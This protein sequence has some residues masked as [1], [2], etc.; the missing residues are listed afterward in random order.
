MPDLIRHP[1]FFWIPVFDGMT[2]FRISPAALLR[3]LFCLPVF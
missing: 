2:G 1:V 3:L